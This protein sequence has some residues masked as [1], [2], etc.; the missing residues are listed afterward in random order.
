MSADLFSDD[1]AS[2]TLRNLLRFIS[3]DY[4]PEVEAY[5]RFVNQWLAERPDLPAWSSGLERP[6]DRVIGHVDFLWRDHP[7]RVGVLPYRLYLLQKDQDVWDA[8]A[9]PDRLAMSELLSDTG[10]TA[11]VHLRTTRRIA[12]VD[13][14]EVWAPSS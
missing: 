1:E 13:Q 4:L 6:Q 8:A 10:L 11:L 5:V 14:L 3:V 2:E 7:V 12:R 9:G